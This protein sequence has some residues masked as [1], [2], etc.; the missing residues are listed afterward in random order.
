VLK[1]RERVMLPKNLKLPLRV[2]PKRKLNVN[3][4][5]LNMP[6]ILSTELRKSASSDKS[7]KF[8][9]QS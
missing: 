2:K 3:H 6:E 9:L 8:L 5:E 1:R 7:K 4:G